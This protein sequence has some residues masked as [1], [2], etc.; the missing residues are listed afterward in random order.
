MW[1]I[2]WVSPQGHRS[3]SASRHFIL[4]APQCRKSTDVSRQSRALAALSR[5]RNLV[6]VSD[7]LKSLEPELRQR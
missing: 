7:A 1:D 4:Q 3:V 5:P 6:T 2:V